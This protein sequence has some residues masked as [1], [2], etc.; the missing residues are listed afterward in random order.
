M[1]GLSMM[2]LVVV[3]RRFAIP[4]W[5]AAIVLVM[6]FTLEA[7][8]MTT[9]FPD[10]STAGLLRFA[11]SASKESVS[12][13]QNALSD[14]SWWG[15]GVGTFG[16]IARLYQSFDVSPIDQAPTSAVLIAVEW[17]KI[18][19]MILAGFAL[20]LLV[21][22]FRGALRR[23]RDSFFPAAA[24]ATIAV[25]FAEAYLDSSLTHLS[26]QILAVIIIGLGL[27]QSVGRSSGS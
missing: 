1:L 9:G 17:G 7:T 12:I 25:V 22:T 18:A 26:V 23:G 19:L 21:I 2:L 15:T 5:S 10:H 11:T 16:D 8:I 3:V 20:Q 4:Y 13:A 27:A 14:S 6:L 24:A